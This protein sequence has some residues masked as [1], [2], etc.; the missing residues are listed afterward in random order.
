[1]DDEK[2]RQRCQ[3]SSSAWQFNPARHRVRPPSICAA[4]SWGGGAVC[5][6]SSRRRD[7]DAG[8]RAVLLPLIDISSG[9]HRRAPQGIDVLAPGLAFRQQG[10]GRPALR[11]PRSGTPGRQPGALFSQHGQPVASQV[12]GSDPVWM[13]RRAPGHCQQ[14][15]RQ[16]GARTVG[17]M[18]RH[19]GSS[20]PPGSP[21]QSPGPSQPS[22]VIRLSRFLHIQNHTREPAQKSAG[23]APRKF[24]GRDGDDALQKGSA[25]SKTCGRS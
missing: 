16:L 7:R 6:A 9:P 19:T 4:G 23:I 20:T 14:R 12:I 21:R 13:G 17:R 3:V 10:R 24:T 22:P 8:L 25:G 2:C 11:L 18:I 15:R 5:S 1:M